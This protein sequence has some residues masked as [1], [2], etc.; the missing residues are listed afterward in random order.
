MEDILNIEKLKEKILAEVSKY[1]PKEIQ[2]AIVMR[3]EQGK[4]LLFVDIDIP[5]YRVLGTGKTIDQ[6]IQDLKKQ[7]ASVTESRVKE[8]TE[9]AVGLMKVAQINKLE[10]QQ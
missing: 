6:A 10:K 3:L 9:Q 1:N 7:F 4:H 5:E 8:L 2:I